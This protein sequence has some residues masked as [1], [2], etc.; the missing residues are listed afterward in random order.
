[1]SG[2]LSTEACGIASAYE[3]N[4][5]G[6]CRAHGDDGLRLGHQDTANRHRVAHRHCPAR[7]DSG[8]HAN[9]TAEPGSNP[10]SGTHAHSNAEPGSNPDSG[11]HAHSNPGDHR[12]C[13]AG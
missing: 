13:C 4:C 8:T 3:D 6:G 5:C 9:P 11:T 7:A 12:Y 2:G 10:D 1:M